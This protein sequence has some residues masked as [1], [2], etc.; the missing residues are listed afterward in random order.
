MKRPL[1]C[2]V[3]LILSIACDLLAES[4]RTPVTD[5]VLLRTGEQ[6]QAPHIVTYRVAEWAQ[7]RGRWILPDFGYYDTGYGKE[8]IWFTG[9][10]A[11]IL[12]TKHFDWEQ[13]FYVSQEAGPESQN[14][15]ALWIWPVL[16]FRFRPR[17]TGQFVAY[18]TIPLNHAQRWGYDVDRSKIEW[19]ISSHWKSGI[20]YAGGICT[21]RTWQHDPLLTVTRTTRAGAVEVWLERISGGAQVQLRYMLVRG[22]N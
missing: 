5:I 10:G 20:G 19:S 18:P 4:G 16:D 1:S 3:F 17:L 12:H 11:D 9:V 22:E 21:T 6:L 7:M 13:E 2:L 14:R 15:R 8:Q